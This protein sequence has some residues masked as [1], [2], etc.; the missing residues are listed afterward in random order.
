MFSHAL[1]C[2]DMAFE[3]NHQPLKASLLTNSN[4][5]SHLSAVYHVLGADWFGRVSE[6]VAYR[7]SPSSSDKYLQI[8]H[9]LRR[10]FF[11]EQVDNVTRG[12]S[13]SEQV[14]RELD[15]HVEDVLDPRFCALI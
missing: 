9:S 14:I 7:S 8:R 12:N 1:F 13:K 3:H 5:T 4:P 2:C 10:L 11:G 15:R 6:L